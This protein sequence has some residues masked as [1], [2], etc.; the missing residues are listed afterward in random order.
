MLRPLSWDHLETVCRAGVH[1]KRS[2]EFARTK[3]AP[4]GKRRHR[5]PH[6]VHPVRDL[7]AAVSFLVPTPGKQPQERQTETQDA[8][9]TGFRYL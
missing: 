2:T 5:L 7:G 8:R 4:L 9:S 6:Q 3:M 1:W